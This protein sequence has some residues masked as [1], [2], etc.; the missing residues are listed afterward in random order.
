MFLFWVTYLIR[1]G[2]TEARTRGITLSHGIINFA[3]N[4]TLVE[5]IQYTPSF[6]VQL[7]A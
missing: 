7:G 1:L 5:W 3:A 2:C 6:S 4:S